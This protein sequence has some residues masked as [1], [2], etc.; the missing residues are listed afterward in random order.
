MAK[1][2]INLSRNFKKLSTQIVVL[3]SAITLAAILEYVLPNNYSP[4]LSNIA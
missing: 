4:L 3:I 2:T 1:K